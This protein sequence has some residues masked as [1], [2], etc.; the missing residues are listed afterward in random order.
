MTTMI[1]KPL[2]SLSEAYKAMYYGVKNM[3]RLKMAMN[4]GLISKHFNSRIMLAVTEVNG[5]NLCSY[6]HTTIALESG[7]TEEEIHQLLGG[8][9][10]DTP[11]EEQAALLFAQS[12]ADSRGAVSKKAWEHLVTIYGEKQ[13]KAILASVEVI[14][15]GNTFG[16]PIGSLFSRVSK[17]D[18]FKK[19]DRTTLSYEWMMFIAAITFL[20]VSILH[21]LIAWLL[22]R[23]Q[24]IFY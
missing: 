15:M 9:T 22:R 2:A 5:C 20:P 23:P 1:G 19:D 21:S 4:K 8:E 3:P 16:I 18:I 12:V 13:S 6:G 7:M 24:A 14:M 17:K 10:S 11:L